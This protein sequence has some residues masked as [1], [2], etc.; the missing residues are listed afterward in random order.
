MADLIIGGNTYRNIDSVKF[1]KTDGTLTT[2][3]ERASQSTFAP[4]ASFVSA[5]MGGV[6]ITAFIGGAIVEKTS[7][8]TIQATLIYKGE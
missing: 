2:F 8:P 1:K 5:V 4:T 3:V 7:F 6:G